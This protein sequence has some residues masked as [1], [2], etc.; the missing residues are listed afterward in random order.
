MNIGQIKFSVHVL[1]DGHF[2]HPIHEVMSNTTKIPKAL[3]T[4]WII[5]KDLVAVRL[6]TQ[7]KD[8]QR[9]SPNSNFDVT[10]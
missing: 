9:I 4:L 6:G 8:K 3:C 7:T 5:L 10:T 2:F 1:E